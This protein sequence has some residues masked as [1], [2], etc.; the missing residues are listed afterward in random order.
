MKAGKN[1]LQPMKQEFFYFEF[2]HR[3]MFLQKRHGKE[4]K[5]ERNMKVKRKE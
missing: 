2:A 3:D 4:I 5:A 1:M